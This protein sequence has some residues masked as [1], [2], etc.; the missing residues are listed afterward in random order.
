MSRVVKL[1]GRR[2]RRL[3]RRVRTPVFPQV[4]STECGAACLGIVMAHH[5]RWVSREELREACA[6]S[7]DGSTAADIVRA[8]GSF[9]L[10]ATGWRKDLDELADMQLPA[11]L[12]WEFNHFSVLEGFAHGRYYLNDPANGRRAVSEDT[13]SRGY[14]GVLLAVE[15]GPEFTPGGTKPGIAHGLWPWLREVK[16]SLLF[17]AVCGLLLALPGLALPALLSVFVDHVLGGRRAELG[18]FVVASTGAAAACIYL[19]VWLQQRC[20]NRLAV[21]LSIVHG[22]RFLSRLLRL[23]IEFFSHRFAGDLTMRAQSVDGVAQGASTL[24]VGVVIE[25]FTSLAYLAAM[26]VYDPAL[27]ALVALLGATNGLCSLLLMRR[28]NDENRQARRE[29]A[30]LSGI[31]MFGLRNIDSLRAT[32]ATEGFFARWAGHQARELASRQRVAELGG[33]TASLPGLFSML[34]AAAV[35]GIGGWR[36]AS[37]EMSIG[38]LVGLYILAAAFLAPVGRFVLFAE[39]F[40]LLDSSLYQINDVM[41]A[42]TDPLLPT[43]HGGSVS[44]VATL[45]GRLRLAGR[46]EMRDVT[47]GYGRHRAPLIENFSLT[48]EPGQRVAV[49]GP[50]GSGK[51]TLVKLLMGEH[52][53]WSGEILFDG[54][55][56]RDIP[57]EVFAASVA[58]VDQQILLF[59]ASVRDN[60]TLW[61][62]TVPDRQL[63]AAATDALIHGE[64]MA[65]ARGYDSSVSEGG[66]NFSGGQ[67][68]RLEIGRALVNDPS[69]L[70]LDEA[71]SALDAVSEMHIDD[72]LRRRGCT[73]LIVAHRL[74]TI[75]DC[76]QIVVLERGREV[77]RGTH[78]EL[79]DDAGGLYR[80][81]VR[82]Q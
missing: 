70:L 10:N 1:L 79:V 69:V 8:A 33:V 22:E 58:A 43:P 49:I 48:V 6:V 45:G 53:P 68:Q 16:A 15:P 7:R 11:I 82:A 63:V 74:S 41:D 72:A 37:G 32:G 12:F 9:G 77:Q 20:L 61:N 78:A 25:L 60:L 75:R 65:R 47:F 19:L 3:A 80:R 18:A 27:A 4:K 14:T 42:A 30:L 39:S 17:A 5:G 13:F 51:S 2:G 64:V 59:A 26:F 62:A 35:L 73:C 46:I 44:G 24:M 50:T 81:L 66:L 40:L 34:T 76:D 28:R 31:G 38:L 56:L 71:T 21:Q 55:P 29:Q 57:R 23:P 67:R 52:M 36:V 54:V